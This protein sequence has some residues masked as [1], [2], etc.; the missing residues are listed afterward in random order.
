MDRL[1]QLATN[2]DAAFIKCI[3]E[4]LDFLDHKQVLSNAA[5]F[6]GN[7]QPKKELTVSQATSI[8]CCEEESSEPTPK[9]LS[10]DH[11][12]GT[13]G[14]L[15]RTFNAEVQPRMVSFGHSQVWYHSA[16]KESKS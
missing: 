13:V 11:K 14:Y 7:G 10:P 2:N 12:L 6:M 8:S 15:D 3:H 16:R 5:S 9:A 1:H 4:L